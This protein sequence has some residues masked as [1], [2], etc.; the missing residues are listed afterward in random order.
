MLTVLYMIMSK[1][2]TG[3]CED[4]WSKAINMKIC[5]TCE[6]WGDNILDVDKTKCRVQACLEAGGNFCNLKGV[7]KIDDVGFYVLSVVTG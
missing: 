7:F 3:G 2:F 1:R 6:E 5:H 4:S